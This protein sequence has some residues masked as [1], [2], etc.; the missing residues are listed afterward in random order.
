MASVSGVSAVLPSSRRRA[1]ALMKAQPRLIV[2][3]ADRPFARRRPLCVTVVPIRVTRGHKLAAS[4]DEPAD[5]VAVEW[6]ADI[7]D[8]KVFLGRARWG[9]PAGIVDQLQMPGRLRPPKHHE[10][11]AA[12]GFRPGSV[13]HLQGEPVRPEALG[14]LQVTAGACDAH[15]TRR[16]RRHRDS[17][18]DVHRAR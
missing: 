7:E 3:D 13:E 11:V 18:L 15:V 16:V 9:L 8:E 14:L 17:M 6:P 12:L 10:G 5:Q 2:V 1:V 4:V